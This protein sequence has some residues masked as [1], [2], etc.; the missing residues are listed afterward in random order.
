MNFLYFSLGVL[1]IIFVVTDLILTTFAP[2]GSGIFTDKLRR[3]MWS[4]FL[5]I[6]GRKGSSKILNYAGPISVVAWLFG[7]LILLWLGNSLLFISDPDSVIAG[8]THRST[9]WQEKMYF[10]SYTLSTLGSGEFIP[11]KSPWQLYSGF[12]SF[13]GFIIVTIAITYLYSVVT[14]DIKRRKVSLQ[15]YHTGGTPQEILLRFWDGKGFDRL[16]DDLSTLAE[17]ILEVAQNHKAYPVLHNFHSTRR[18]QSLVIN[19]ACLDEALTL[20]LLYKPREIEPSLPKLYSL[21]S[22]ITFY[23]QTLQNA[24][25]T[26]AEKEPPAPD[27]RPLLAN[28]LPLDGKPFKQL[29]DDGLQLRRKLL[30]GLLYSQGWDWSTIEDYQSTDPLD[31]WLTTMRFQRKYVW[32]VPNQEDEKKEEDKQVKKEDDEDKEAD[33]EVNN[34]KN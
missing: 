14:N 11:Y 20:L 8:A 3:W 17:Q 29:T 25:I 19:I 1:I 12:I 22:A 27:L 9:T 30:C 7:W 33:K 24:F 10:T 21:R 23:L 32:P 5:K 28:G 16:K 6:S 2:T 31:N 26:P 34:E 18:P 4:F 15:I 13:S